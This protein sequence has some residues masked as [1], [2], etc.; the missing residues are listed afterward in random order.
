MR[1]TLLYFESCPNWQLVNSLLELLAAELGFDLERREVQTPEEAERSRFRG[2]PTVLI[3][4]RDPFARGDEPVGLSCRVY[5]TAMGL[6]G[7]PTETQLR[8]VLTAWNASEE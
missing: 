7:A 6:S 5:R 2:S 8:D 1:I 4:G 3:D